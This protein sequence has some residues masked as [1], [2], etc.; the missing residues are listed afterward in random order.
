KGWLN[1]TQTGC[2]AVRS[3]G[4][5]AHSKS[6][7]Q[8][9][10][11]NPTLTAP[12]CLGLRRCPRRRSGGRCWRFG[13]GAEAKEDFLACCVPVTPFTCLLRAKSFRVIGGVLPP[14]SRRKHNERHT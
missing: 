13:V 5:L 11:A 3:A 1:T 2:S 6:S 7:W 4:I 14:S 8:C 9:C 12:T 10:R